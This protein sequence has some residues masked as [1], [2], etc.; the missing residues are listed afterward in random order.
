MEHN[1][2]TRLPLER[3]PEGFAELRDDLAFLGEG[4]AP[5][6]RD[7]LGAKVVMALGEGSHGFSWLFDY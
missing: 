1:E 7:E 2:T 3:L 5:A 6:N 4:Q